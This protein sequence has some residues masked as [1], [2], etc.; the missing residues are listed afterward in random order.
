MEANRS[1][2]SNGD[3]RTT[4]APP[5]SEP[6]PHRSTS[7]VVIRRGGRLLPDIGR[8][9]FDPRWYGLGM[10]E[11]VYPPKP[12]PGD[13]GGGAVHL[14]RSARSVPP[15]LRH[16]A[17]AAA[18]GVRPGAGGV[19]DDP[20]MGATA[21]DRAADIHAAFADP[22]IKAV[23]ASIGGDD[24]ITVLP[25]LDRRADPRQPQALLRLQRQHEP[26]GLPVEPRRRRL[27]RRL[28]DGPARAP[29]GDAPADRGLAARRAV[30]LRRVR[31]PAPSTG[32][33]TSTGTGATRRPSTPRPPWGLRRL[34]LAQRRP[35][36]GGAAPGAATWRSSPGC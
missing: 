10:Y 32:T 21:A 25:Y 23:I 15:P 7:R 6:G 4:A 20:P 22:E 2:S 13:K 31:A 36:G 18:R 35:G 9:A 33:A 19:S 3:L 29:G 11:P 17:S 28:G 24:Q 12:K 27:P 26:A 16:G 1:R 8:R 34:V 5:A 14:G 30:H